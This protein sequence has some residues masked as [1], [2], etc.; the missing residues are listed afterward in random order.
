MTW[1]GDISHMG[2]LG[3]N[4][5]KLGAV[6]SRAARAVA[7]DIASLIEDEFIEGR[8]PY[9]REWA[10]LTEATL[11]KRSQTS[12]PPL[13]DHGTMRGS[14]R[15]RPR[16]GAGVA[17]TIDHPAAPHQTGWTGDQGSGPARPILPGL[18]MPVA[19]RETIDEA[20]D[21][22]VRSAVKR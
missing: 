19:W 16:S 1:N 18:K 10:E 5:A 21:A 13:T 4:I 3:E 20:V 2:Q 12:E 7:D 11:E 17:I 14:V 6:P 15:V 8:D 22:Q 9:G